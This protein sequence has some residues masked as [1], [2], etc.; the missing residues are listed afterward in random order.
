MCAI[1]SVLCFGPDD[2]GTCGDLAD[3]YSVDVVCSLFVLVHMD[4]IYRYVKK[5][6]IHEVP[7]KSSQL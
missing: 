2:F 5:F 3:P 4:G 1:Y 7:P 6:G